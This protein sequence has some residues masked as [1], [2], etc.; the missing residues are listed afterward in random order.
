MAY[1]LCYKNPAFRKKSPYVEYPEEQRKCN[2]PDG[3]EVNNTN[4]LTF[5]NNL[6]TITQYLPYTGLINLGN[7]YDNTIINI[8][9]SGEIT[10]IE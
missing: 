8:N 7:T 10:S 1:G 5:K 9:D 4:G 6:D 3:I 2:F